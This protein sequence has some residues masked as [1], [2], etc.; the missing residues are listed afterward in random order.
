[1]KNPSEDSEDLVGV[2]TGQESPS[3]SSPKNLP[4]TLVSDYTGQQCINLELMK[5]LKSLKTWFNGM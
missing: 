5:N 3:H 2:V 4:N 1:M